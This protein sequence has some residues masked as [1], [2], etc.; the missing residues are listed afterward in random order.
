MTTSTRIPATARNI[1]RWAVAEKDLDLSSFDI[2]DAEAWVGEFAEEH[3]LDFTLE[4][5]EDVTLHFFEHH[6]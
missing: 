1:A 3:G 6:C 2:I 5:T 4:F